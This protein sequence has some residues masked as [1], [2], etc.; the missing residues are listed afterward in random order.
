M[1]D[2]FDD[3]AR[4]AVVYAQEE[5]RLLGHHELGAEHLLVGVL[6][7]SGEPAQAVLQASLEQVRERLLGARPPSKGSS[8][9]HIPFTANAKKAMELALRTSLELG[10]GRVTT[11]HLLAGIVKVEDPLVS[12]ALVG[13]G[14]DPAQAYLRARIWASG[15]ESQ[16]V[17]EPGE[18]DTPIPRSQSVVDLQ[19]QRD[20][21]ASALRRYGHHE[22]ACRAPDS[23][24]TCGLD[25]ALDLAN[26][27]DQD[28][29]S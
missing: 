28:T 12:G 23:G 8:S 19:Q 2:R 21:L 11:A 27:A 13:L 24:C 16:A 1:F 26:N 15:D 4:T 14:V 18:A 10:E 29:P 17:R 25:E 5:L 7:T 3:D 20:V 9:G 6:R 22:E